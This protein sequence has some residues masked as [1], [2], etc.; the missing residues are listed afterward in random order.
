MSEDLL[1]RL[2]ADLHDRQRPVNE[3][4]RG[5]L[6]K[7][8]A[9]LD[10][11]TAVDEGPVVTV[12]TP[13]YRWGG[14]LGA[15][16]T[17]QADWQA[18][19]LP[20]Q[21]DATSSPGSVKLRRV[22]ATFGRT[23]TAISPET[24]VSVAQNVPR[25]VNRNLLTANQSNALASGWGNNSNCALV[26]EDGWLR[27]TALS[28]ISDASWEVYNSPASSSLPIV[29][30]KP[31]IIS[32]TMQIG[33]LGQ[34]IRY[35]IRHAWR[36]A[37]GVVIKTDTF[38][39]NP[40]VEGAEEIAFAA[41]VAPAG[42]VGLRVILGF[43]TTPLGGAVAGNW[44]RAK[45]IMVEEA[46][47]KDTQ[48]NWIPT[49]W[50][51]GQEGNWL[52]VGEGTTNLLNANV[53]NVE[54]GTSGFNAF[55]GSTITQDTTK[56]W[57][58]N[59]SLKVSTPGVVAAEGISS[60][61]TGTFTN[62]THTVS[63]H[64]LGDT[65]GTVQMW[66]RIRYTDASPY[67]E[68]PKTTITLSG[69]WTRYSAS[70]T[71]DPTKTVSLME[72]HIR[73]ATA[74]MVTLYV[75]GLQ[76]E[77]KAYPT[78]WQTGG[79]TRNPEWCRADLPVTL[80]GEWTALVRFRP[81]WPS[82]ADVG[83]SSGPI[84]LTVVNPSD[85]VA[86][87]IMLQY[88]YTSDKFRF[89]RARAGNTATEAISGVVAFAAGTLIQA[90]LRM[91]TTGMKL[92]LKVGDGAIQHF[93]NP[94]TSS[95]NAASRMF[96]G[97]WADGNTYHANSAFDCTHV[98]NRAMSDSEIEAWM[99]TGAAPIAE[100][101]TLALLQFDGSLQ[102]TIPPVAT[103]TTMELDLGGTPTT[104]GYARLSYAPPPGTTVR[105]TRSRGGENN[106]SG[107]VWG[108]WAAAGAAAPSGHDTPLNHAPAR[109]V[110]LEIELATTDS[111]QTPVLDSALVRAV[112]EQVKW[113]EVVWS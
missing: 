43:D 14:E 112:I 97:G 77:A 29:V 95:P 50:R 104:A 7:Y 59:A 96:V 105:I 101:T 67:T 76:L 9:P 30:G 11:A 47:V 26:Y 62:V 84:I 68:G 36:D 87:R 73:T 92:S 86:D 91:T 20:P 63:A 21:V 89:Y 28:S 49:P 107:I 38:N 32:A 88:V 103:I 99:N 1:T 2:L 15:V 78:T 111:A 46:T 33:T 23:G 6:A 80:S 98:A 79:S 12:G 25:Y 40:T 110:Q 108:A 74:Q 71:P 16:V 41:A 42:A 83:A 27:L 66:L 24:G 48:G 82:T 70:A 93:T 35:H 45:K 60:N 56:R 106:G 57:E 90:A 65:A 8:T 39:I 17:S 13:P 44:G 109:Y 3:R 18:G 58:G 69:Q 22:D 4:P 34:S 10:R 113:N 100:E 31:Y 85:L 55:S 94:T 54:S 37:A 75:D 51:P 72:I 19:P 81:D 5:T 52:F 61:V 102:G 64:I 53:S